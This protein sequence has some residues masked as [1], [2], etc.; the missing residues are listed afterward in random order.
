M[1]SGEEPALP[2]SSAARNANEPLTNDLIRNIE[3]KRQMDLKQ[4]RSFFVRM[5]SDPKIYNPKIVRNLHLS[6]N[7]LDLADD[8][9][10]DTQEAPNATFRPSWISWPLGLLMSASTTP[11]VP[12]RF[13]NWD[14]RFT[15]K[16]GTSRSPSRSPSSTA[17]GTSPEGRK[18][19]SSGETEMSTGRLAAG[20]PQH[21]QKRGS[22]GGSGQL[23]RK[24]QTAGGER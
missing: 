20:P 5:V 22:N 2:G 11:T 19:P 14:T 10:E 15:I 3:E 9:A 8:I 18:P 23:Q 6:T 24:N 7:R 13:R 4:K 16:Q 12:V 21:P 17:T 1:E